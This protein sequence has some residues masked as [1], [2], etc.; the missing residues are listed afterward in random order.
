M[1]LTRL[2]G[3]WVSLNS[4]N[5]STEETAI[6]QCYSPRAIHTH[7][8]L[9]KLADLYYDTSFIPFIWVWTDLILNSDMIT[10]L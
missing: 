6:P 10:N 5:V 4:R 3:D 2:A 1:W 8:V 7:H 9:M